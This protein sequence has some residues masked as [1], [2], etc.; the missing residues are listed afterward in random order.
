MFKLKIEKTHSKLY[1]KI[2]DEIRKSDPETGDLVL[3]GFYN[4]KSS[5]ITQAG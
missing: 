4:S 1:L 5:K 2:I 3:A